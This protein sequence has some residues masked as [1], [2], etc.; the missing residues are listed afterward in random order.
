[1]G[2]RY[3]PENQ[4]GVDEAT[5]GKTRI[6]NLESQSFA[7]G[8]VDVSNAM[9]DPS[10]TQAAIIEQQQ[11]IARETFQPIEKRLIAKT[12]ADIEP[13]ADRAGD[14]SRKAFMQS[15]S[16]FARDVSRRG[17]GIT[18]AQGDALERR[19]VIGE[20]KGI[21]T[22]ENITRRTL[23]DRNRNLLG[24]LA[25]LGKGIAS[26]SLD[27]FG[28]ASDAQASREATGKALKS[29]QKASKMGGAMGGAAIGFQAGG[30]WG[31]AAGAAIGYLSG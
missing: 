6:A 21:A 19:R 10:G 29:Q 11:R 26:S 2:M 4:R 7:S 16:T 3:S 18:T 24:N 14:I 8:Q 22:A 28:G 25:G 13:E 30:P 9:E 23:E 5:T 31:A 17:F 15:R 1:M 27:A 12:Q 20:T